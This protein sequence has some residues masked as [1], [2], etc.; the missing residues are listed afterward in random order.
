MQ[1]ALLAFAPVILDERVQVDTLPETT[2][3]IFAFF[4]YPPFRKHTD[5]SVPAVIV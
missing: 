5:A 4:D 3:R 1:N 2:A